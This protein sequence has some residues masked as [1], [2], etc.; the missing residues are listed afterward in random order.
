MNR[1]GPESPPKKL[2]MKSLK[3]YLVSRNSLPILGIIFALL[4]WI[5]DSSI[6]IVIF[7]E[8]E[9]IWDSL[10][11]PE[12]VELWMRINVVFLLIVFSYV[13]RY[14]FL[15][16]I[17]ISTELNEYKN[18]L[19]ILVEERTLELNKKNEQLHNEIRERKNTEK[20]LE[21][22]ASTDSL[23]SLYNRRKF[24]ELIQYE[25]ERE[26]RYK[27]GLSLILCDIDHFKQINDNYGHGVGDDVLKEFVGKVKSAIRQ[28]DIFARWGGEEFAIL[29]PDA[30]AD[31][32][33]SIAE[34][35]RALIESNVFTVDRTITASFGVAI[36]LEKEDKDSLIKRA[37]HALYSAKDDGRN[38]VKFAE[39]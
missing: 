34:K 36:L 20:K 27:T 30:S 32:A 22:L 8:S 28:T 23:T 39:E 5:I 9:S 26:R 4:F 31:I 6:D 12:P 29:V 25:I 14:L 10:F 37:D 3:Q 21:H 19:E 13:A 24:D 7:D 17:K 15:H 1:A 38:L 11:T 16:Q 35:I 2:M 18:N 33:M